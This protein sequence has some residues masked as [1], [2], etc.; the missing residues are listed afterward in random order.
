MLRILVALL[1]MI[2]LPASADVRRATLGGD[3]YVSGSST[4]LD[5]GSDRDLFVAGGTVV[6]RGDVAR[7]AHFAGLDVEIETEVGQDVY[8]VGGTVTLR[9]PVAGDL[10]AAGFATRTAG[11]GAVGGNARLAGGS[12]V[13]GGPIAG[14]LMVSGGEV[15]VDAEVGG[16]VRIAAGE[17]RFGPAARIGGQ[18][19]YTAPEPVAIPASVIDPARVSFTR[20][21]RWEG[22]AA[23]TRDWRMRDF[24]APPR[25]PALFGFLLITIAFF[26]V[27]GAVALSLAPER[28]EAM[29]REALARPGRA[30][31]GGVL[32]LATVFGLVPISVMTLVGLPLLPVILLLIL[33]VWIAGYAMGVYTVALRVWTG[34]GGAEPAL[35]GR[36]GVFAGGLLI[37]ALLNVIPFAGW[38]VN[39]TLVLFGIGAIAVPVFAA[40]FGRARV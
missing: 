19:E 7:N 22:M 23:A 4:A 25:G 6:A 35:P 20:S 14:S 26:V 12:V 15:L 18:L 31:L 3:V 8:A 9:A 21:D 17:V 38:V 36:L 10:T 2:S 40:L 16:D 28:I 37:V 32:G 29:R 24:P 33:I 39:F 11:M 34:M 1:A 5:T 27:L 30:F 13:V